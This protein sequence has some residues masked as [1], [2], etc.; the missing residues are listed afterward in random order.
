MVL[1]IDANAQ[2]VK[3]AVDDSEK[4]YFGKVVLTLGEAAPDFAQFSTR[5][6]AYVL[7]T[8]VQAPPHEA[9]DVIEV[10]Y[11]RGQVAAKNTVV[12]GKGGQGG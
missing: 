2:F 9:G 1:A 3:P 7:H 12:Q 5:L 10:Q 11:K 4:T 6:S 8:T